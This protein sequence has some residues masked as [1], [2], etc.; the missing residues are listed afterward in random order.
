LNTSERPVWTKATSS[1]WVPSVRTV[2]FL[3]IGRISS[4]VRVNNFLFST[5]Q[6]SCEPFY[7]TN[8]SYGKQEPFLYAYPLHCVLLPTKENAK[9][10]LVFG[11]ILLKHGLYFDYRNQ[12]LNMRMRICYLDCHR[13]GLCCY[14][15][16]HI[17]NY[18]VHYSRNIYQQN[19]CIYCNNLKN[20]AYN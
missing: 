2:T 16:I 17:E 7:V 12:P 14:I 4:P 18:C 19:R 11:S 9:G 1:L 5:R 6:P 3:K 13:A 15:V 8:T 10:N 20:I